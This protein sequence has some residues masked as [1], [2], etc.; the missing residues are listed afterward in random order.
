[1]IQRIP[2]PITRSSQKRNRKIRRKFREKIWRIIISRAEQ[3][4]KRKKF[5]ANWR[6]PYNQLSSR[7]AWFN[8]LSNWIRMIVLRSSHFTRVRILCRLALA[9][10]LSNSIGILH[11]GAVRDQALWK[12]KLLVCV[13][14]NC[15]ILL[16][17]RKWA[18]RKY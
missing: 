7:I 15:R 12:A 14:K 16:E 6:S 3:V 5:Q 1:M 11:M 9:S 2:R 4:M 17:V 13:I 18:R 8:S 10:S